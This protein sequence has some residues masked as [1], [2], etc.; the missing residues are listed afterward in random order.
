MFVLFRI[1]QIA[2][3]ANNLRNSLLC[4]GV[5]IYILLHIMINLLGVMGVIPLTG[6]PL[7][8]LSYGGSYTIC[9][10]IALGLVQRVSIETNNHK[11]K[12][13]KKLS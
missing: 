8:F 10:M 12:E 9:L 7:P 2:R 5:F 6:V 1:I 13:L 11:Q 4:Y 3:K